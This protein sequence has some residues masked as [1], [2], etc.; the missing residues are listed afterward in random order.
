M[1]DMEPKRKESLLTRGAKA[2]Q[3]RPA[4]ARGLIIAVGSLVLAIIV[5]IVY[6]HGIGPF[7][8]FGAY[9]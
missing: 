4:L 6:V 9:A 5:I 2:V 8:P 7:G 1:A 3:E